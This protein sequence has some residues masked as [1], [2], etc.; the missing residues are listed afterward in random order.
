MHRRSEGVGAGARALVSGSHDPACSGLVADRIE[1][2]E[3]LTAAFA[4]LLGR[5]PPIRRGRRICLAASSC[6]RS[7]PQ[8]ERGRA[9]IIAACPPYVAGAAPEPRALGARGARAASSIA[10]PTRPRTRRWCGPWSATRCWSRRR[11]RRWRSRERH[12]G[13][14]VVSLDGTVARPDG[15]VSGGSGDDVGRRDG[16]AEARDCECSRETSS[17][18]TEQYDRVHDDHTALR[19]RLQ[20]EWERASTARGRRP[21][22][23]SWLTS[24]AEKDLRANGRTRSRGPPHARPASAPRRPSSTPSWR[25]PPTPRAAPAPSSR[26][27][28][29]S[30]EHLR[31]DLAKAESPRDLVERTR[32]ARRRPWSPSARCAW[33]RS[34]NRSKRGKSSQERVLASI[35][36]FETRAPAPGRR[37]DRDRPRLRRDR[38]RRS[39]SHARPASAP[40]RR[41]RVAH[42]ELDSARA[43]LEQVRFALGTREAELKTLREGAQHARRR[44][45]AVPRWR[46]S[47][48]TSSAN[49][50]SPTCASASAASTCRASS[51]TT[52]RAPCPTTSSA[53]ASTS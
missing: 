49:T 10:W 46:C 25:T 19:A 32:R 38:Q 17:G 8:Q 52:T 26:G 27:R 3:E 9:N 11:I 44:R 34:A 29:A 24:T 6:W 2:P 23:A 21:T 53:A 7:W 28:S 42:V 14:T 50:C 41:A 48:S 43:L 33:R 4:G 12:I 13:T 31:H 22:P 37:P 45:F 15:V 30:L 35:A 36:D 18:S 16:R 47:A 51:A 5:A 39:C 20:R 1:A 40:S